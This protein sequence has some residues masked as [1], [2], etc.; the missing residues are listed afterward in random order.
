MLMG[1]MFVAADRP[2]RGA[3]INAARMIVFAIPLAALGSTLWGVLGIFGAMTTANVA[4]GLIAL[5]MVWRHIAQTER[6]FDAETLAPVT[7]G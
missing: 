2:L 4:V 3:A 6:A 7:A 5:A 1:T